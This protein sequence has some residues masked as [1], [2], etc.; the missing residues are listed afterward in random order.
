M[1]HEDLRIPIK[2]FFRLVTNKLLYLFHNAL[3]QN[4]SSALPDHFTWAIT[5]IQFLYGKSSPQHT[6]TLQT[7]LILTHLAN[8]GQHGQCNTKSANKGET[9][10][11]TTRP[12]SMMLNSAN[13]NDVN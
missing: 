3:E 9:Q 7:G 11:N 5:V 6:R 10:I 1:I 12:I 13:I 4:D 2:L 8:T